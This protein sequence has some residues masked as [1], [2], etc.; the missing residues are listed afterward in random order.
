MGREDLPETWSI[1]A[2]DLTDTEYTDYEWD[3]LDQGWYR[4]AVKAVYTYNVSE[5]VFSNSVPKGYDCEITINVG[6]EDG[7]GVEGAY[8]LL[9][10]MTNPET[11]SYAATT[12]ASGSI[13]LHEVWNGS[14]QLTVT[15]DGYNDYFLENI[16]IT[17]N[18]T[19]NVILQSLCLP[20]Q[21]FMVNAQT[22]VA[23][24]LPPV[25]EYE[26]VFEEGFEGGTIPPGWTQ[27]YLVQNVSWTIGNGGP[28]GT[29]ADPHSGE[30]NATFM[31]SSATTKLITPSID[32][33]GALVP[34][35]SFWHT[36][37]AGAGQDELRV[38]YRTSSSGS[39]VALASYISNIEV[40]QNE[41]ISLPNLEPI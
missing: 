27:Q 40:W 5:A 22:G 35:L 6:N 17:S 38:Y 16:Y 14:Y 33:A 39:W 7:E 30:F 13:Y 41:S 29:P 32:L 4:Y 9:E 36:Q 3:V 18:N 24:W 28:T 37:K 21:N 25:V 26:V 31:G 2:N 10:N 11:Y 34:Q 1:L 8:V 20:P 15:K 23:T 19:L 12:P